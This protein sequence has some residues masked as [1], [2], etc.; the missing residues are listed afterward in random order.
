MEEH[1]PEETLI[2]FIAAMHQWEVKEGEH[3]RELDSRLGS[4][5]IGEAEISQLQQDR[6]ARQQQ[7][8]EKFCTPGPRLYGRQGAFGQPPEYDPSETLLEVEEASP[9]EVHIFT[10]QQ[11]G[12]RHKRRYV[13]RKQQG[14]WRIDNVKW[15]ATD[16]T[17]EQ[18]VL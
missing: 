7:I 15:Q 2:E 9:T 13:L 6:L 11:I 10:E 16:S 8:F 14:R 5:T 12:F 1:T 18:G 17:W 4:E 3:A